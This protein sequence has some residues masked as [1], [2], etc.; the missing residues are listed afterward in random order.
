MALALSY[1]EIKTSRTSEP[2]ATLLV[3]DGECLKIRKLL[4]EALVPV[5]WL[6]AGQHPLETVTAALETRRQQ[7]QPVKM[8]HWVSHGQPG[9]LRVGG[10]DI[11]R[12]A[13]LAR[14]KLIAEW[15]ISDLAL[16]S[17]KAGAKKNFIS[18]W[19]ELTGTRVW[20][21]E[22]ELGRNRQ[23]IAHWNLESGTAGEQAPVLPVTQQT[24][25]SW[26]Y[27]LAAPVASGT[28]TL[29]T[30][31]EDSTTPDGDTVANLFRSSFSDADSDTLL[32]VAITANDADSSTE[33]EWQY[34]IDNGSN[35][36]A[37]AT[38]D[39]GDTTAFYLE[40]NSKLRSFQC[41][42]MAHPAN[43]PRI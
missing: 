33:G 28:P 5:L 40:A 9:G 31:T 11:G 13:L 35:W 4:A 10:N 38:T 3:A 7:G 6:E 19:Q 41:R 21:T 37:V 42:S 34:S 8:L 12:D 17:C 16:W 27:Q 32:G 22:G 2:T 29:T 1:K 23:G 30:I 36:T 15:G 20:S 18:L 24:L 26:P 43:S 39:L 25:R 14:Q